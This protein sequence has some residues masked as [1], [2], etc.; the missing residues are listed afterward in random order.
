MKTWRCNS[1]N[2]DRGWEMQ[3]QRPDNQEG[4]GSETQEIEN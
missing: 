3:E 1:S 2:G 4:E